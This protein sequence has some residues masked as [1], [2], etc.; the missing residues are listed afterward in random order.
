MQKRL[1]VF[2]ADRKKTAEALIERD[3]GVDALRIAFWNAADKS[4]SNGGNYHWRI[5]ND[6]FVADWQTAGNNHIHMTVRAKTTAK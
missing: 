3:G 4:T 6:T 1:E 2:S 5:G